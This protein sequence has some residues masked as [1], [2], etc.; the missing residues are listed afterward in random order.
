[1]TAAPCVRC[2]GTG[3]E[4]VDPCRRCAGR[5][6]V[7]TTD[8]LTVRIPAG[9]DDGAQLRVSG[10]G[11]AGTR[12]GRSGDLYVAIRV[13]PHE[14]FRRSGDDLGC[15]V[16]VPMTVAALGGE[17][18]IPT[19]DDPERIV[20]DPGTQSGELKRLRGRGMPRIDGRGR[21]QLVALLRVETPTG[22]DEEQAE[23]LAQLAALRDERVGGRG[24]FDKIKEAF[25]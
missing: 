2:G 5:G 19:L 4:I 25:K 13:A 6:R 23:L 9:V 20:I 21:G 10:R 11:E 15:E 3:E 16:T 24:L 18:E 7:Q 14:V 12:G 22:L 1:M 8:A 17:V